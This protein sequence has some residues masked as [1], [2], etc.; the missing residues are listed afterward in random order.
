[1]RIQKIIIGLDT[2]SN[3]DFMYCLYLNI[4]SICIDYPVQSCKISAI[5]FCP[6][7]HMERVT[8][9]ALVAEMIL[10]DLSFNFCLIIEPSLENNNSMRNSMRKQWCKS[11]VHKSKILSF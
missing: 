11:A 4:T 2:L 5:L 9:K 8:D 3:Q 6:Y 1:M 10:K 7:C